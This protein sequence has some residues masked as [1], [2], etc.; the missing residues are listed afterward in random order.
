MAD[1]SNGRIL[2]ACDNLTKRVYTGGL[3]DQ[4]ARRASTLQYFTTSVPGAALRGN[5]IYGA[6]QYGRNARGR[7]GG[8]SAALPTPGTRSDEQWNS[9]PV[10]FRAQIQLDGP[11]INLFDGNDEGSFVNTM[12]HEI[13]SA[14]TDSMWKINACHLWAA[15]QGKITHVTAAHSSNSNIPVNDASRLSVGMEI[16]F[17]KPSDATYN[18]EDDNLGCVITAV[19]EDANTITVTPGDGGT[20]DILAND[21]IYDESSY[22][23]SGNLN[24]QSI[25]QIVSASGTVQNLST[26]TV[27]EW[28]SQVDDAPGGSITEDAVIKMLD[29]LRRAGAAD[30][31]SIKIFCSDKVRR[32]L[33][34]NSARDTS[35]IADR[36]SR[37]VLNI[38][39]G[40]MPI[41]WNGTDVPLLVDQYCPDNEMYFLDTSKL[42]IFQV[43]PMNFSDMGG[44]TVWKQKDGYDAIYAYLA[45]YWQF[46]T[47]SRAAHGKIQNING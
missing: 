22:T 34:D 24:P 43:A 33:W 39:A 38:G 36:R 17:R 35:S 4:I 16:D 28:A 19:D 5:S 23:S 45:W 1:L 44:G 41:T 46:L 37:P 32:Y 25:P 14:I 7:H 6:I 9:N 31:N 8:A 20:V 13:T 11:T 15:S 10:F 3:V 21:G 40:A 47:S 42:G 2:S 26:A 30:M 29:K 12:D 27:S 18:S